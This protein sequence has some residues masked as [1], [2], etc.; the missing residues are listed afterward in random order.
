LCNHEVI[1]IDQDP[2]GKQ[3]KIVRRD[4]REMLMVKEL[5]DGSKAIGL[6]NLSPTP[7]KLTAKWDEAGVAGRQRV[8]DLWRQKDLG[9][10]DNEFSTIIPRHGVALL[11]LFKQ[12]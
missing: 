12:N 5:E 1:D 6:F 7:L 4:R 10:F 2:L 8:R 11:R 3:A 9:I